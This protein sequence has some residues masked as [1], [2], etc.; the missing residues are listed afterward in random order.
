MSGDFE[1]RIERYLAGAA[2]PEEVEALERRVAE[3]PDAA[4]ALLAA[5]RRNLALRKALRARGAAARAGRAFRAAPRRAVRRL[6]FAGI[7]AA[8]AA[9]AVVLLVHDSLPSLPAPVSRAV[10]S[11]SVPDSGR[12]T[13]SP[14]M[15]PI[16]AEQM[17]PAPGVE[18]TPPKVPPPPPS[19]PPAEPPP[20]PTPP[21]PARVPPAPLPPTVAA[22]AEVTL[23]RGAVFVLDAGAAAPARAG[24]AI[25][26]GQGLRTDRESTARIAFPDGSVLELEGE[27]TVERLSE[28]PRREARLAAGAVSARVRTRPAGQ[29]FVLVT[30]HAEIAVLG[31][32]FRV[33]V[34]PAQTGVAV[35]EGRVQVSGAQG[36]AVTASAGQFVRAAAGAPPALDRAPSGVARLTGGALRVVYYDRHTGRGPSVERLEPGIELYLPE[37][38]PDLPP[39]GRDRDF[40]AVWEGWFLA[41]QEGEYLFLLGVDGRARLTIGGQEVVAEPEGV[42]HPIRRYAL[43]RSL[44]SGWHEVKLEYSDNVGA[45]RCVLRYVPPGAPLPADLQSDD[46]GERIPPSLWAVP[47]RR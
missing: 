36:R 30:P 43:R 16:P 31:T 11:T 34:R 24:Q 33:S 10:P 35:L 18:P 42:F 44:G 3:D 2:R 37:N 1:D 21:A 17:R 13:E 20:P 8:A 41:E 25:R 23:A 4:R 32:E 6:A 12:R 15:P 45:S 14:P 29:A 27:T 9:V 7:A 28:G 5:A 26:A 46:A 19:K 47:V 22:A 38:S 40:A 39:I